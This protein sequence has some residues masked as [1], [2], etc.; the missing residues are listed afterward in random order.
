[1][2]R[3]KQLAVLLLVPVLLSGCGALGLSSSSSGSSSSSPGSSPGATGGKT[4]LVVDQGTPTPS[5]APGHGAS[6]DSW[7]LPWTPLR[8]NG[9]GGAAATAAPTPTCGTNNVN[10]SRIAGATAVTS[11]T[12]AVVSWYNDGGYNLRQ[13]R[14]TAISQDLVGGKQRDVGWVTVTPTRC[15]PMSATI[16]GLDRKTGYVFS[17]DAVVGRTVGDGTQAAT[18][19][20]SGVVRTQ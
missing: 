5:A 18:I 3:I 10:F 15:G 13:F 7:T 2:T 9:N 12:G 6:G 11:A 19:A 14:V 4:W 17:V 20:R 8:T 1:V 16:T